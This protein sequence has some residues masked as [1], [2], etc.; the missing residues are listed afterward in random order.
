M[1]DTSAPRYKSPP[2]RDLV[3]RMMIRAMLGLVLTVLALVTYA[4]LTDAPLVATPADSEIVM[5][6]QVFLSGDMSGAVT[7]LDANG[8]LIANLS[9]EEGGFIAGVSRVLDRERGKQGVSLTGPV[10]II[11]RKNGRISVFDPSTGWSADLMG[12]GRSNSLAFTK[13]LAK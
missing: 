11:A 7:I 13:L 6:R 8:A 1:T 5:E 2:D 10:S 12:F 4:R 3:P 9:P